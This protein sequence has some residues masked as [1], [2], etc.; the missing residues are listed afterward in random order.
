MTDEN[1]FILPPFEPPNPLRL[2]CVVL[3]VSL[4]VALVGGSWM[5]LARGKATSAAQIARPDLKAS[6]ART[7][8]LEAAKAQLE[9]E[10]TQLEADKT[11]L[12]NVKS[13]LESE[14]RE[15]LKSVEVREDEIAELKGIHDKIQDKM[16]DEIARGDIRLEQAGNRLRVVLADRVLFDSAEVQVAK[17]G[18]EVLARL[19]EVLAGTPDQEIQVSGHTDRAP[20]TSKL[21]GQYPTNWELSVA[22]ATSVVRFLAEKAKVPAQKLAASGCGEHQPIASNKT[23]V[24]RARNRRIEILLTPMRAPPG[25]AKSK[26]RAGTAAKTGSK[27]TAKSNANSNKTS[28]KKA[29]KKTDKPKGS[30]KKPQASKAH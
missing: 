7:A 13:D 9:A 10:K 11:Q 2:P 21:A 22:R 29:D 28:S 24:G 26:V 20:V 6:Q 16:K 27:A 18:E 14:K 17:R 8:A 3:A 1:P 15:L 12:E 19:A 23:A 30:A 5:Y 4:G 25:T